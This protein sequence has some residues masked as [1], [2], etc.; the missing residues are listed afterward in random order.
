[1]R[2][3]ALGVLFH[4]VEQGSPAD[5]QLQ[6]PHQQL[7]LDP[8][9]A[10]AALGTPAGTNGQP[11]SSAGSPSPGPP[12]RSHSLPAS[13]TIR[14]TTL[15]PS[16]SRSIP[17]APSRVRTRAAPGPRYRRDTRAEA[18]VRAAPPPAGNTDPGERS[19]RRKI[20]GAGEASHRWPGAQLDP[21][22]RGPEAQFSSE[23]VIV[24]TFC[25]NDKWSYY[26]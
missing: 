22:V 12:R 18:A 23:N 7:A 4:A 11:P 16:A 14:S 26:A 19:G 8:L 5:T 6:C 25:F 9:H 24:N 2:H 21:D 10:H 15:A 17:A 1:M 20:F 13:T 3:S